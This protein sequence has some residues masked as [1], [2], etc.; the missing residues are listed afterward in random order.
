MMSEKRYFAAMLFLPLLVPVSIYVFGE[1]LVTGVLFLSLGFSGVPYIIFSIL[2]LFWIR[3]RGI[4]HI[5]RL[6]Y[7]SPIL[8]IPMQ[9]LYLSA[10]FAMDKAANTELTGLGGSIFVSAVYIMVIGYAYV[11]LVNVV[12]L[13][14][15]KANIINRATIHP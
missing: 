9:A 6:S 3:G 1:N 5:R 7:V 2:V 8:F 15:V 10:R 13:S 14:L 4:T 12:Y 11:L